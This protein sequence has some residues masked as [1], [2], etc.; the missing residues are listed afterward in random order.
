MLISSLP[1][2]LFNDEEGLLRICRTF[3]SAMYGD[4]ENT[5]G[6]ESSRK[7][8]EPLIRSCSQMSKTWKTLSPSSI[9]YNSKEM[10][11]WPVTTHV[12]R[13]TE[14]QKWQSSMYPTA[15]EDLEE[16]EDSASERI[17]TEVESEDESRAKI[18]NPWTIAKM[19]API[20][21]RRSVEMVQDTTD[22]NGQ[23]LT[24]RRLGE[25]MLSPINISS[26]KPILPNR[27]THQLPSPEKSPQRWPSS[28]SPP[29]FMRQPPRGVGEDQS[30]LS[31][32]TRPLEIQPTEQQVHRARP[33]GRQNNTLDVWMRGL[34]QVTPKNTPQQSSPGSLSLKDI[35]DISQRPRQRRTIH[36]VRAS[37]SRMKSFIPPKLNNNPAQEKPGS[38]HPRAPPHRP[39]IQKSPSRQNQE[40]KT[41]PEIIQSTNQ[42]HRPPLR[43]PR[44]APL[45]QPEALQ[46]KTSSLQPANNIWL[47]QAPSLCSGNIIPLTPCTNLPYSPLP[48]PTRSP[49]PHRSPPQPPLRVPRR[50]VSASLTSVRE[51]TA[52][53]APH[54]LYIRQGYTSK[55]FAGDATI[56]AP[57]QVV[58]A[59]WERSIRRLLAARKGNCVLEGRLDIARALG[60]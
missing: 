31:R 19:N 2:T 34:A 6:L 25:T 11:E 52:K 5:E 28:S 35:P 57:P 16:G 58:I 20:S 29:S 42:C 7:S 37:Q 14:S 32:C 12:K 23:L 53:L 54:D 30:S 15:E 10:P 27:H 8:P 22:L 13:S 39:P 18:S 46:A 56:A 44:P 51:G 1:K 9:A 48:S 4:L 45:Y 40:Q 24:P 36:N 17:Q 50:T 55:A 3:F 21:K 59:A 33:A 47:S 41:I 26:Y 49:S 43:L 38:T 60:V